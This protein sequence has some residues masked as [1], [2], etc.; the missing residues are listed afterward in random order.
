MPHAGP[1]SALFYEDKGQGDAILFIPGFGG[2][3]SFW[4]QQIQYFRG[5]FRVITIDQRGTG[6]SARSRQTYSLDQMAEDARLV[7]DAANVRSAI[8]VGHSTGGAIA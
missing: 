4:N 6:A 1:D 2:V 5:R 7:L 8:V 3:G